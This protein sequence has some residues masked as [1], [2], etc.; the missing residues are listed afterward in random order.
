MTAPTPADPAAAKVHELAVALGRIEVL[1]SD[2]DARSPHP[3]AG[4]LPGRRT[5]PLRVA[6][7]LPD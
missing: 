2:A 6:R 1:L 7:G 3:P 5:T 4:G